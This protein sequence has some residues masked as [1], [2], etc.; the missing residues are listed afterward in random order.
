MKE[1]SFKLAK[2]G[3]RRYPTQTIMNTDYADDEA[4]L[5]NTPAQT[6]YLLHSLEQAAGSIGLH[7]KADK[8]EYIC[9]NQRGNISS[10]KSRP[11]KLM[12]KFTYFGNSISSTENDINTQLAKAWTTI[13]RLSVIWKSDLI[14]EIKRSLFQVEGCVNTA[15]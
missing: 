9:F 8:T 12:D 4:L 14:D 3:S 6:E 11:L 1:N 13:D 5:A 2:E 15:I 10:L 7:V